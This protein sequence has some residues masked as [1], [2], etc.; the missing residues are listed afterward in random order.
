MQG[1]GY[2]QPDSGEVV[3]IKRMAKSKLAGKKQVASV[4]LERECLSR[5]KS[6]WLVEL[7]SAFQDRNYLY[8]AME[9]VPGGDLLRLLIDRDTFTENETRFYIGELIVAIEEMHRMHYIHRDIKP[10]NILIS[11]EGHLK[12][13]DFGLSKEVRRF[14]CSSNPINPGSK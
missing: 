12:L 8:I 11:S 9:W 10:D 13:T 1:D 4:F 5:N 14:S 6:R 7:K 3:A 2:V